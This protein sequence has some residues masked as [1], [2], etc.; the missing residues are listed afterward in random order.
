MKFELKHSPYGFGRG[1]VAA[2]DILFDL[3]AAVLKGNSATVASLIHVFV[4]IF[5]RCKA[6][7]TFNISVTEEAKKTERAVGH[8]P[9]I[10]EHI[11][12]HLVCSSVVW[13]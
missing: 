9:S 2:V 8:N 10:V 7:G 1:N 12:S 13:A 6:D 3:V 4:D 5:G 11:Y